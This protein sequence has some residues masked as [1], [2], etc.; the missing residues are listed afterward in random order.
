MGDAMTLAALAFVMLTEASAATLAVGPTRTY[1]TITEAVT[2]S[3]DGDIITVDPGNYDASLTLTGRTLTISALGAVTW[4]GVDEE[5]L[6]VEGGTVVV[7]GVTFAADGARAITATQ[8]ASVRIVNSRLAGNDRANATWEGA[9]AAALDGAGLAFDN[10]TF[11]NNLAY[12]LSLGGHLYADNA[13][14][15]VENASFTGGGAT[16]GG[17]IACTRSATCTVT[18]SDFTTHGAALDGGVF[19]VDQDATLSLNGVSVTDAAAG[20]DGGALFA[21]AA[22]ALT[23]DD[24]DIRDARAV[25]TGGAARLTN[26]V[27]AALS[28]FHLRGTSARRAGGVA[29]DGVGQTTG[30]DWT[31][32]D[33]EA[34]GEGGAL[35]VTGAGA[36]TLDHLV[37]VDTRTTGA[38]ANGEGGALW[39]DAP[40][41]TVGVEHADLLDGSASGLGGGV[42]V[43]RGTLT[44]RHVLWGWTTSG[45]AVSAAAG[46]VVGLD[47][48]AWWSNT[49]G[50][51]V[52]TTRG[53]NAV[54]A[55]PLLVAYRRN[56]VCDDDDLR[57][58]PASP[59]RDAGDPLTTDPDGSI[60]D[61]G[62][63]GGTGARADLWVDGDSDGTVF[64][65]DCNDAASAVRP[66]ATEICN[67]IDDDCDGDIDVAAVVGAPTWYRDRD[68]DGFGADTSAVTACDPPGN[69][70]PASGDCDDDNDEI[71][72]GA[73]EVCNDLDDN[74]DGSTD[75]A[76]ARGRLQWYRDNDDDGHGDPAASIGAC[77]K[78]DGY[79]L[80]DRDCDDTDPLVSPDGAETCDGRDQD[81]DDAIDEDAEGATA[82]YLDADGDGWG[83]DSDTPILACTQPAGAVRDA[84]DCDDADATF[85]PRATESCADGV[86]RNCDGFTGDVD[87]DGDGYVACA[88]CDDADANVFP[89]APD[90][91]Y[92]GAR[93]DCDRASD[94]DADQDG[95][96]ALAFG[97]TDCD[98]ADAN[99]F[100][101]A[102][103]LAADT[104]DADC[105][106]DAGEDASGCA[107]QSGPSGGGAILWLAPFALLRRRRRA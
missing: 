32:C 72:P 31:V 83:A 105:D 19:H 6:R 74:C 61:I 75:G 1:T 39:I 79:V 84:G 90:T 9:A 15:E 65:Y 33:S 104:A 34:G 62:A 27:A 87:N 73:E 98:D 50:D 100:P 38:R 8:G 102:L 67:G 86:D 26:V 47:W 20:R 23:L 78:P 85:S 49:A 18:D 94:F 91:P 64:A 81:C 22:G 5:L 59:L 12:G 29:L 92:D 57:L 2:A 21:D 43:A 53:A 4:S 60:A 24:V 11:E 71:F 58:N 93:F 103:D 106:G 16:E 66:G 37:L 52:G 88:D 99:I 54:Q 25:E 36:T 101:G 30:T 28:G 46:T 77:D 13:T 55:D 10:C 7:L 41:G 89:G 80:S 95:V 35:R 82:W 40:G 51:V 76:D 14:L 96:D 63:T 107:C 44:A 69:T 97:G 68:R 56:G 45:V 48:S 17:A 3:S 42:R 70:V